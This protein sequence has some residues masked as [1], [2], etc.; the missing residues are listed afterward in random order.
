MEAL[1]SEKTV[2]T[3][4]LTAAQLQLKE[5]TP[6]GFAAET[7]ELRR[8]AEAARQ[9]AA[10][11]WAE[12]AAAAGRAA[13]AQRRES[14][15]KNGRQAVCNAASCCPLMAAARCSTS[16]PLPLPALPQAAGHMREAARCMEAAQ[17]ARA[18]GLTREQQ[19]SAEVRSLRQQL[20]GR[21]PEGDPARALQVGQ[22]DVAGQG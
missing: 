15:V 4:A 14:E 6:A 3:A 9:E 12:A 13:E 19:L 7:A 5:A 18:A 21:L 1:S 8:Q 17:E 11:A 2:L 16:Q 10:A 20:A 22:R